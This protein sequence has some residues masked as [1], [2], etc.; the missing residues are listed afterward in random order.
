MSQ[1]TQTLSMP[2]F[3]TQTM[4]IVLHLPV[5]GWKAYWHTWLNRRNSTRSKIQ[6]RTV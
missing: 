1:T 6:G 2:L 3:V 4:R 5:P